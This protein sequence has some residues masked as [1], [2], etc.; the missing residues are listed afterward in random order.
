MTERQSDLVAAINKLGAT[1]TKWQTDA[2]ATINEIGETTDEL[3]GRIE[4]LESKRNQPGLTGGG[5]DREA[6]E[7]WKLFEAWI[8]NPKHPESNRKL[9]E[10]EM[11]AKAVSI[12]S[13]AGG[14]YAVPEEISRDIAAFQLKYSPVRRLVRVSRAGTSDMKRL[15][16]LGGAEGGW[17]SESGTV[18]ESNTPQL[19][20]IAPT[21]GEL[22]A[23]PKTSNWSLEDIF[24]DVRAWLVESVSKK[25]AQLEGT[26][27]IS[28]DGTNKPTG[29]LNT[30]P[31]S[32]SD[33]ASPKR[34]AAA[35]Q[36]INSGDNRRPRSM[37]IP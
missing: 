26:A 5:G 2:Q 28:G 22:Y 33:E 36:Y 19:R 11:H 35:Y 14:G 6:R 13:P 20:E 21:G 12:G 1:Q 10:F 32:T 37:P 17:R 9:A 23:Y 18:S 15:L 8:R 27:V 16:D 3:R 24:F 31:V 29:M 30:T 34:A 7:H 25:F 4:E